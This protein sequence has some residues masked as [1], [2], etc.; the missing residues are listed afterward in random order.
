MKISAAYFVLPL[1][2]LFFAASDLVGQNVRLER[3]LIEV[4]QEGTSS[5]AG[6]AGGLNSPQFSAVDFNRDGQQDLFVFDRV[7]HV[8]LAFRRNSN[9]KWQLQQEYL[10]GFPELDSWVLLRDYDNDGVQDIF[11]FNR[12]PAFGIRVFKGRYD[13]ND[14]L[15]F[16]PLPM[17]NG[18]NIIFATI[19]GGSSTNLYV[20]NIDYPDINDID[21]DGDLDVLTFNIS[22]GFIEFYENQSIQLGYGRDSLIFT[23]T[24]DCFG[25][26]YESGISE[27]LDLS[28]TAGECAVGFGPGEL[29]DRHVGSTLLTL[30]EDGDGDK[31]LIL[32]DLAFGNLNMSTNAG[33]CNAP[34]MNQQ[35]A[36]FPSYDTQVDMPTFPAAFYLD[37][38]NDGR[39]D[40]IA[41][42]NIGTLGRDFDNVWFYKNLGSD[43]NP[44]FELQQVDFLVGDMIDLGTQSKPT[45]LDYNADGLMD[46]V[47]GNFSFF[48]PLALEDS[49]LY[50]F[51]NTGT[52]TSPRFTL[53]DDDYLDMSQYSV[54]LPAGLRGYDFAP[55]FG[56]LDGDGDWDALIGD[57]DGFLFFMENTAGANQ[58]VSF[59]PAQYGYMGIDIGQSAAPQIVDLN[60]DGLVDLVIG[61]K[62]GN[63]NYFQNTGTL[64]EPF[65]SDDEDQSPNQEEL[66]GIDARIIGFS[67]GYAVPQFIDFGDHF[68][69]F[70]GTQHRTLEHYDNIDGNLSGDFAVRSENLFT[71]SEGNHVYPAIW[72][73]NNDGFLDVVIGNERGGLSYFSTNVLMDGTVGTQSLSEAPPVS[74]YPNPATEL[75]QVEL[76]DAWEGT[77]NWRLYNSRGQVM[78]TE[79][80][81]SASI[82]I[83]V[84]PLP[85]GIYFLQLSGNQG[86]RTEKIVVE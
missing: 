28:D 51:E 10:E 31:D 68:E 16:D 21:C 15:Q 8:P 30:D 25:G 75:L 81:T 52:T 66:G 22:G 82:S 14:R 40:L 61:E 86:Q 18:E 50:L 54:D 42:P 70:L 77:A 58:P 84:A 9:G 6:F 11:T 56:D 23:R 41:A 3:E 62:S 59:G 48:T 47:V 34:W 73:F 76:S 2:L 57:R 74:I 38:D 7:G 43:D 32:G 64:T 72:D 44:V 55:T 65:F 1:L 26:I 17:T 33:D 67:T 13:S 36:F 69:L 19:P 20:S 83:D 37:I 4:I 39:R 46:V 45:V 80:G 71:H 78:G 5:L 29:E 53:V 49:R 35:D 85:A 60:R 79:Q 12:L 27:L 63:I 24:E